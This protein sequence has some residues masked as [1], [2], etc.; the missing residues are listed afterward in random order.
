[1]SHV[2]A[3][4]GGEIFIYGLSSGRSALEDPPSVCEG[5]GGRVTDYR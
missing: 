2:L 4:H 3:A 5:P 1:M